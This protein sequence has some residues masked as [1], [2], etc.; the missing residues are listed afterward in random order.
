[1]KMTTYQEKY[2]EEKTNEE[3]EAAHTNHFG[4]TAVEEDSLEAALNDFFSSQK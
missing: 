1:M 2:V 3:Y 4:T